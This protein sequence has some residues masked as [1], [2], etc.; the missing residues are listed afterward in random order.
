MSFHCVLDEEHGHG[1]HG[2]L[3]RHAR[4]DRL[5]LIEVVRDGF[6]ST[7]IADDRP[8]RFDGPLESVGQW[9]DSRTGQ[10]VFEEDELAAWLQYTMNFE[11]HLFRQ[12]VRYAAEDQRHDHRV[13]AARRHFAHVGGRLFGQSNLERCGILRD[14]SVEVRIHVH[15]RFDA[16]VRFDVAIVEE[17]REV[18]TRA[19]TDLQYVTFHARVIEQILASDVHHR[20]VVHIGQF[21]EESR[22]DWR[23]GV[24]RVGCVHSHFCR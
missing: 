16:D 12:R 8:D 24:R 6:E 21:E 14:E 1:H 13:D 15:V 3:V 17:A 23:T 10:R 19:S 11:K 22:K 20:C 2:L 9:T 5:H 4:V 18:N 7:S